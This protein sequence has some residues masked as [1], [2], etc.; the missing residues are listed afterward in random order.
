MPRHAVGAAGIDTSLGDEGPR[1]VDP[2]PSRRER[3]GRV[4]KRAVESWAGLTHENFYDLF[5]IKTLC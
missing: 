4:K 2:H 3:R 1:S 5:R